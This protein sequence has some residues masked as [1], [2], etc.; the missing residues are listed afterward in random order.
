MEFFSKIFFSIFYGHCGV[1]T[2]L[3]NLHQS[4][5]GF[6]RLVELVELSLFH[7]FD[8]IL[9]AGITDKFDFFRF[10]Q[11]ISDNDLNQSKYGFDR[12]VELLELSL[13][14]IFGLARYSAVA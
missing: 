1:H 7:I 12:L 11:P 9:Q 2:F 6:D 10:L 4:K 3:N 5:N 13:F 14:H 8:H